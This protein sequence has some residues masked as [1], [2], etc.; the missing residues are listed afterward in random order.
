MMYMSLEKDKNLELYSPGG[1]FEIN[2]KNSSMEAL[3]L[4]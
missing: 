4:P 3:I 1:I 2:K